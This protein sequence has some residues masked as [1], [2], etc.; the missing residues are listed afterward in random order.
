MA[1]QSTWNK[2]LKDEADDSVGKSVH[3]LTPILKM[4]FST[5]MNKTIPY[6]VTV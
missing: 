6:L 1:H 2:E 5:F 3:R 4:W